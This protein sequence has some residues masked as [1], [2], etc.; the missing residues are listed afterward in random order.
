MSE[1]LE[2]PTFLNLLR[3]EYVQVQRR[4]DD[5]SLGYPPFWHAFKVL[6]DDEEIEAVA[7]ETAHLLKKQGWYAHYWNGEVC[8]V[9]F[10]G[11]IM[12]MPQEQRGTWS[13]PQYQ[14]V[15]EYALRSGITERYLDFLIE[16]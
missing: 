14:A 2:D 9:C 7:Q 5:P 11:K 3:H 4:N 15:R 8:I 6:V 13:S 10:P 12:H 1:S 16:P